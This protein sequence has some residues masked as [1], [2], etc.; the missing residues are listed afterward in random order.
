VPRERPTKLSS[1]EET[2]NKT[3]KVLNI[4]KPR[5]WPLELVCVGDQYVNFF[6]VYPDPLQYV[7]IKNCYFLEEATIENII[8]MATSKVTNST[9]VV[10]LLISD[11]NFFYLHEE[12]GLLCLKPQDEVVR[13]VTTKVI[14]ALTEWRE[15]FPNLVSMWLLPM[16]FDVEE[17]N[18]EIIKAQKLSGLEVKK[19]VAKK[20]KSSITVDYQKTQKKIFDSLINRRSHCRLVNFNDY[21]YKDSINFSSVNSRLPDISS[22]LVLWRLVMRQI[23]KVQLAEPMRG[24]GFDTEIYCKTIAIHHQPVLY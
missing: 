20:S 14:A 21:I 4:N 16:V 24:K 15:K 11:Q 3:R 22:T 6:E 18:K 17:Y 8:S 10:T 19:P 12:T 1:E 13:N 23:I 7:G 5:L 9:D 2:I